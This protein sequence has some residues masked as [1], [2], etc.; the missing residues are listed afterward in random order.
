VGRAWTLTWTTLWFAPAVAIAPFVT[1]QL[2]T[3]F[4]ESPLI[5]GCVLK[6]RNKACYLRVRKTNPC[7][8]STVQEAVAQR[9]FGSVRAWMAALALWTSPSQAG[10]ARTAFEQPLKNLR[11]PSGDMKNSSDTLAQCAAQRLTFIPCVVEADGGGLGA[12]A[13]RVCGFV[14]KAGAAR[15]GEGVEV[16]T[17]G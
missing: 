14:A 11:R 16:Q 15:E 10:C 9:T 7:E 13:R 4:S 12:A 8:A 3:R 1:M 6:R 5:Q 2:G 17:G